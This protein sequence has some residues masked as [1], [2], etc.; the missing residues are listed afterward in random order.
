[1][2][3]IKR[4]GD[5]GRVELPDDLPAPAAPIEDVLAVD[6]ALDQL[7]GRDPSAAALVKLHYFA[8]FTLEQSADLLG[9]PTRT[10]Y[11]A[12]CSA[13]A[14]LFRKLG[15]EEVREEKKSQDG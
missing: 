4:G 6:E 8:G 1:K 7:A 12:W 14:W 10:A 5:G 11:R 2:A 13:R 9:V 15:G 3:R